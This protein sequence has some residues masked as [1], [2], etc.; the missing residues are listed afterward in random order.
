MNVYESHGRL[1]GEK[2]SI[3]PNTTTKVPGYSSQTQH[4]AVEG[5]IEHLT[6]S[7]SDPLLIGSRKFANLLLS[8]L[9][10]P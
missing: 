7:R 4:I 3:A 8:L 5:I 9:F 6:E 10:N 1:Y 2:D